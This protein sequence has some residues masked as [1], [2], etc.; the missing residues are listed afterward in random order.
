MSDFV[1]F[2]QRLGF[3]FKPSR[4]KVLYGGRGAGKSHS[5]ATALLIQ[6]MKKQHRILCCRELQTSISDSVHKLLSDMIAKYGLSDF[7]EVQRATIRGKNGTEFLF[8]GLRHNISSIKSFEGCS[9]VWVEEAQSVTK[10]SWETLI[11]T[12]RSDGSEIWVTFNP[13]F[14]ED[15]TYQ[16]F[17]KNPPSNA[18]VA[19]VNWND[20]PFFP[21]VLREEMESLKIRDPDAYLTTWEGHCRQTL[22]GAIYA[23][24]LRE[25]QQFKRITRVPYSPSIP[26]NVFSDLGWAD[27]TSL[28]FIQKVGFEYRIIRAYQNSQQPWNHYMQYMQSLGYVY[29]TIWL[30]HDARA[31][32]LGTGMSIEEITRKA[33]FKVM[34]APNLSV[35]D[36]I[37]A[38]RTV[39]P[40][41]YF[42]EDNC[43]D[44]LQALRR[45]RYDVDTSSGQFSRR[46]LHDDA[47]HFAD[48]LR[49]FAVGM[50]EKPAKTISKPKNMQISLRGTH[51][52]A[53][54][55]R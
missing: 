13:E 21:D 16:R 24:E 50:T 3:L 18:I 15:E 25:A 14:E 41:I 26:V 1:D 51:N 34:I 6:G 20:N 32:S 53:T 22:D 5:V 44:G 33:G 7:Y 36:G 12:I 49:Y 17:V 37:N 19:K 43:A 46:P 27:N 28:W 35:E 29:D 47:S 38:V 4:Y 54:W 52:Q 42:D 39:F 40:V 48:G 10:A 8:A 45:Y 2:P 55:M 23:K 9:R 30:P 31:K 11:P